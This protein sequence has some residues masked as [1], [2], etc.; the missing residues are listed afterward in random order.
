MYHKQTWCPKCSY[1]ERGNKKSAKLEETLRQI[2]EETKLT[3]ITRKN[4]DFRLRC[5][6]GH[7]WN[8]QRYYIVQKR[9]CPNCWADERSWKFVKGSIEEANQLA[10]F[11]GGVCISTNSVVKSRTQLDFKCSKGHIWKTSLANLKYGCWCP[12]CAKPGRREAWCRQVIEYLTG[13]KLQTVRPDWLRSPRGYRLELDGYCEE[14]K[15]A[16]EHQGEQH[17][18]EDRFN[19]DL[20]KRQLY[21]RIKVSRCQELGIKL[22]VIP[23]TVPIPKLE[24]WIKFELAKIG[25]VVV[26][27]E[28]RFKFLT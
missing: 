26:D 14:A 10:G 23:Y 3:I 21:D 6:K 22:L 25:V 17:F 4:E 11:Y 12:E 19:E 18:K 15:L 5:S 16:F 2:L 7:E 9:K 20:P 28:E 24:A 13:L 27:R 1:E 8:T